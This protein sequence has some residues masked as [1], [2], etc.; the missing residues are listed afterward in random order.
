MKKI[1]YAVI[2]LN[3]NTASDAIMATKSVISSD[4]E[5][6]DFV[7]CVVDGGSNKSNEKEIL[8]NYKNKHYVSCILEKNLGYARG[9]NEGIKF[10]NEQY[11]AD[12]FVIMNPDV[13]IKEKGVIQKLIEQIETDDSIVG[14]QPLVN[15][16]R[17]DTNPL[18]Q[19]NIRRVPSY[20][21]C[22][23]ES[24]MFLKRIFKNSYEKTVYKDEMPYNKKIKF[25]VPSGAFFIIKKEVFE[26]VDYFSPR[27]FL[28][29]EENILGSRVKKID[30]TFLF[31]PTVSVEHYQGSSTGSYRKHISKFSFLCNVDSMM[32][33]IDECLKV[34][35]FLKILLKLLMYVDFYLKNI[36]Y[37]IQ[38]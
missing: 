15:N 13:I 25:E 23:I 3:Y 26:K 37:K 18:Y 16:V 30:K 6:N 29:Q 28:Y 9:N 19:V 8:L 14:A 35:R 17:V 36:I 38:N 4:G 1:K 20:K 32:I 33:Y 27:T 2:I 21:D 7:V 31:D 34:P 5:K 24:S 11:N 12:Y 22:V 10:I